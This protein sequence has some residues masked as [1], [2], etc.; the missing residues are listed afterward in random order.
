MLA[1]RYLPI[2][3]YALSY[4]GHKQAGTF[5]PII[6]LSFLF[7]EEEYN[8]LKFKQQDDILHIVLFL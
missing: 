3:V 2:M 4:E 5:S 6:E 1:K 7:S 8:I